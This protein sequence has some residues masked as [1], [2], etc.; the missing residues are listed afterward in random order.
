MPTLSQRT[1]GYL[2]ASLDQIA[3]T[4]SGKLP[5]GEV[6]VLLPQKEAENARRARKA[7]GHYVTLPPDASVLFSGNRTEKDL[8]F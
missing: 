6:G 2:T 5:Q 4:E 3:T 7:N 1:A 8:A